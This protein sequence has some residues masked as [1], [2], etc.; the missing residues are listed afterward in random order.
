MPA[1][2]LY[3]EDDPSNLKLVQDILTAVGYVVLLGQSAED[4]IAMALEKQP[5]LILIDMYLPRMNGIE[6]ILHLR[7]QP[8]TQH[9]PI[10]GF[11]AHPESEK[12][13]L[14]AGGNLFLT[15]PVTRATLLDVVARF[16]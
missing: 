11:S 13:C 12:K 15:K 16:V 14:D 1:K 7:T 10:I 5:D 6:V 3:I 2:I 8:Q 9:T 4:G